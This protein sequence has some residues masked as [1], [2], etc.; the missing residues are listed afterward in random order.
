MSLGRET[1]ARTRPESVEGWLE[2][3]DQLVDGPGAAT[4]GEDDAIILGGVDG[5]PDDVTALVS[6]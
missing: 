5:V 1:K 3:I 6:V 2:S 4:A